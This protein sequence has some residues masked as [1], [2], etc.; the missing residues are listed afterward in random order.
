MAAES[1]LS[2]IILE[3]V[4]FRFIEPHIYSIYAQV[5]KRRLL[6]QVRKYL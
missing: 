2:E 3:D 1:T 5:E 4:K 6:R